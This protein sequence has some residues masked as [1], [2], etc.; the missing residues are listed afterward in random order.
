MPAADLF[1]KCSYQY[2]T[3]NILN[4][5][6]VVHFFYSDTTEFSHYLLKGILWNVCRKL[7]PTSK[8]YLCK[9][10]EIQI[11]DC[12]NASKTNFSNLG[13]L[14]TI[15]T[16]TAVKCMISISTWYRNHVKCTALNGMQHQSNFC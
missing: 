12:T 1:H 6:N 13:W 2:L 15:Q 9:I 14:S 11:I 4:I 5:K 3:E 8:K 7:N 16:C 10:C